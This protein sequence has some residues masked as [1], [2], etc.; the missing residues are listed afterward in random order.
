[1]GVAINNTGD[2]VLPF[3]ESFTDEFAGN[4]DGA[5]HSLS[6]GVDISSISV[7]GTLGSASTFKIYVR[8]SV[9]GV[10]F[11][12]TPELVLT[13]VTSNFL[14]HRVVVNLI[15]PVRYY[16]LS[17]A[18]SNGSNT[19]TSWASP[20]P[21]VGAIAPNGDLQV[22]TDATHPLRNVI[23]PL[24][25][26]VDGVVIGGMCAVDE[27]L[28]A[29]RVHRNGR[30]SVVDTPFYTQL[31]ATSVGQ[32][33]R[34]DLVQ[35]VDDASEGYSII[36]FSLTAYS[37]GPWTI[38]VIFE[39]ATRL[40]P[41]TWIPVIGFPVNGVQ[42]S[43]V[44]FEDGVFTEGIW[45]I[46]CSGY[47]AVRVRIT[48]I[49]GLPAIQMNAVASNGGIPLTQPV[50]ITD[51]SLFAK[52]GGGVESNALLVTVA[53]DST[54]VLSIDDGGGSLTIDGSVSLSGAVDTELPNAA[55]LADNA[56]NPTAPAVGAFLMG[57]DGSTW[58]RVRGDSTDGMLINLG[59]NNDVT[60]TGSVTANAGTNLDTSALALEAG[61]N[62]AGAATSLAVIDDWDES[63]RAK[64]NPIA[65]QAGVQGGAGASTALTQRVAIATDANV[66]VDTAA[67]ASLSIMDDWDESDRAKVNPIAGQ[68]GVQGGSGTST[69]L[70][71][72]VVLATD[73]ALPA[74]TN[75]LGH[76]IADPATTGGLT[77]FHL[78]SAA[79]TNATVVKASA[80]QLY[81]WYIYNSN[82]AARKVA[83]HN[84][85][86]AP[87][88]GASIFFTLVIPAAS[89]AN[90]FSPIGIAFSTGIAITTVTGLA[91]NN[92]TAVAADDLN[93]NLFYA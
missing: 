52:F 36:T 6:T 15:N 65:G 71:Q 25:T 42:S 38:S 81:G 57:F 62:L 9:D 45:Q 84:T 92:A 69:A 82:A 4:G 18:N 10:E 23:N 88:A 27:V 12:Y 61:G 24:T 3:A 32:E 34:I 60:V 21:F 76:V 91:D 66:V 83:F 48:A 30:L 58:D 46:P 64:V 40:S 74:G 31:G 44:D 50:N 80:G 89:G 54:G 85:A 67:E 33:L 90:A 17:Q 79:T 93:I 29:I 11:G 13:Q 7:G 14:D 75:A 59:A 28:Q 63:D 43:T 55:A 70:T 56:A 49:T 19:I 53:S 20:E 77:T 26:T 8:S 2:I 78:E 41:E 86:S 1:M 16:R 51:G 47:L 68:A 87:T 72:R 37:A 22:A 5:I 73:V 35:N 39:A